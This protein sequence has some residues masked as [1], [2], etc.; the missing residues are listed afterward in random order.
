M[1]ER[2]GICAVYYDNY[3]EAYIIMRVKK[4]VPSVTLTVAQLLAK[5]VT[6]LRSL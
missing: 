2:R 1:A 3:E 4:I 6:E 5:Q